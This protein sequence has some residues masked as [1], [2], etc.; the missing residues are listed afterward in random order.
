MSTKFTRR[1]AGL[2][3]AG[4]SEWR[5]I[6][7][8]REIAGGLSIQTNSE[9]TVATRWRVATSPEY[10]GFGWDG[11]HLDLV[12]NEVDG[13]ERRSLSIKDKTPDRID[14]VMHWLVVMSADAPTQTSFNLGVGKK[15]GP[16]EVMARRAIS[17]G[18]EPTPLHISL[19]ADEVAARFGDHGR[20]Y[21]LN[22]TFHGNGPLSLRVLDV[23]HC[24]TPA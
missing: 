8:E 1:F 3:G 23:R 21:R 12:V 18:P 16:Y 24:S 15:S 14:A 6:G 2:V 7:D 9:A 10:E 11:R 22:A 13:V 5:E 17:I 4:P 20:R 19:R